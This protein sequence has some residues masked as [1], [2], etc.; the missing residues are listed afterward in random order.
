MLEARFLEVHLHVKFGFQLVQRHLALAAKGCQCTIS[1]L[2]MLKACSHEAGFLVLV[3]SHKRKRIVEHIRV[4]H[5]KAMPDDARCRA[6]WNENSVFVKATV[7]GICVIN[8]PP[9]NFHQLTVS[10][11]LV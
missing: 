8:C 4:C 5:G 9:K 10:L 11:L 1:F 6:G 7:E 2:V 3:A